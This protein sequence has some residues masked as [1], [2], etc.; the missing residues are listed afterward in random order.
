MPEL[1]EV[2]TVANHLGRLVT[3]RTIESAELIRQRLAPNITA[4]QFA[5]G[6]SSATIR[7]IGRRGKHILFDLNNGKTLIVH[8]RMSGRFQLLNG[9]AKDPK[10]TH[11]VFSLAGGERLLFVDQ[12]HF[13]MMNIVETARLNETKEI[14]K[15]AP[16]PFSDDFTEAYFLSVLKSTKRPLK[17]CLLDQTKVCGVGNI[18]ASEAM[19]IARAKPTIPA[20]RLSKVK[21]RVLH[22]AIRDVM[23]E[24]I[25]LGRAIPVDPENIGGNIYGSESDA[26]W[27]VYGRE[28]QP[29]PNCTRPITRITQKSRST[30]LCQTCQR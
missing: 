24:T 8:L 30:F 4:Q 18:Y 15:L 1:P 26:E 6:L 20:S 2:E 11:A 29:C 25:E 14:A 10:F 21:A 9:S 19:F 16:E 22:A 7:S 5:E 3:G 17:D 12:R 28:G 27:R 13:G 23:N